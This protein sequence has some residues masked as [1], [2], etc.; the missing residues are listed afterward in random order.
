MS[1]TPMIPAIRCG[2]GIAALA[3]A[4]TAGA[5][6]LR[7][8]ATAG[9]Y[10]D[11][12]KTGIKP[13]LEKQGY[14]MRIV[15]FNDYVQPNLALAQGA[16]QANV[17]QN[18]TYL[19]RFAED[20]KLDL[21]GVVEVPTVPIGLYS[22]RHRGLDGVAQ[23]ATVSM[24]N[25]PTNQARSLHMLEQIGW[26]RLRRD[27]DPLR[28]SERDVESNPHRLKL[29]PLEAA[30]TARALADVDYAFVNGNYAIA[31]GL[32]LDEAVVLEKTLPHYMIVVTV[33]RK[34]VDQPY[35][36]DLV[37]AYRSPEFRKLVDARYAG[38]VRPAY[39]K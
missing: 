21:A 32:K 13:I 39:L 7:I 29:V 8:G 4:A 18:P 20:H 11:Q 25:D 28:V 26:I 5:A 17:F 9:P 23:G 37:A 22:K 15:E 30:Q 31:S 33:A 16:I 1:V 35:V 10:A 19:K 24:P 14:T 12:L 38:Y 34:D 6:E 36:R 3:L 2:L 27:A